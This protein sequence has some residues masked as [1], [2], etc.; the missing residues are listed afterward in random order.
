MDEG[1]SA[2]EASLSWKRFRGGV[3]G[4]T[5]SLGTLVDILKKSPDTG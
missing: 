1:G 2:D 3:L 4:G 5:P